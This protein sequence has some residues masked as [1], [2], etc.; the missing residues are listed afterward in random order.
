MSDIANNPADVE[1]RLWDEIEKNPVGMLMIV[2]GAPHHAQ[3]M[4]AFVER[5]R[6]RVW[7][8]ASADSEVVAEASTGRVAM[9]V[10]QHRDLQAC[11]GG[12]LNVRPDRAQID[13]FWNAVV[14]A[15][16][17]GGKTD[18]KLTMLCL[19][20]D[21]ARVWLS[22]AGPIKFLWEIAKANATHRHPDVGGHTHLD[23]H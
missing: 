9:F 10:Y 14:G 6:R 21:D 23:F 15:Y 13:R 5:E 4:S 17:P 20:C 18:P 8:F 3:P 2:G 11:I 1:H 19:D 12:H 7:F 22:S 16:Y